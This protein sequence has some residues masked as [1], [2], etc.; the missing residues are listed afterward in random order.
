MGVVSRVLRIHPGEGRISALAVALMCVSLAAIAVGDSGV[1]ALFFD[2]VGTDALPLVYLLQGAATFGVMLGLTGVLG[3]LGPRRAYLGAP[4]A[5]ALLVAIE[6]AIVVTDVGWIYPVLWVTVAVATL[7]QG[8]FLWGIA[9]V[10]VDL[11]QAKRLFPIFGAGGILGSVLG[12]LLTRPLAPAIGAENLLLVWAGGLAGAFVLARIL[13]GG[14]PAARARRPSRRRTSAFRDVT[15]ALAYVRR[16]SLLVWM[17]L[18]GMLFS[19]LFYSLYLPFATAA[20]ERFPD[21]DQLAGFFGLFWAGVTATAF[22]VSMLGTNRLIAWVGVAATVV[23]LPVLYSAAFGILLFG[24]GFATLVALR[25]TIGTWLQGVASPGWETLTNVVPEGRRDQV[26]AFLNG[27]PTQMGTI[28][29]G[30]IALVGQ[31]VLSAGQFA[32]IGLAAAVVTIVA[33]I[34]VRRSY[35]S[36]LVDALRAG[37]PQVFER[38]A[39]RRTPVPMALDADSARALAGS[40][41]SSDLHERRLAFQLQVDLPPEA[42]SPEIVKGVR[43]PDPIVRLAAIRALD[44]QAP[45]ERE[46]LRSL[47][48]DADPTVVA[49]AAARALA[50][51]DGEVAA[52][53]LQGLLTHEDDRIRHAAVEQLDLAPADAAASFGSRLLADPAPEV[54]A[55]AL[56]RVA[57]AA[58]D[59]ALD[60]AL[61]ALRDEDALVRRAAGRALGAADGRVLGF[62]LEALVDDRTA[63][64]A[65]EAI[66]RIEPDGDRDRVRAFVRAAAE[67]AVP[68]RDLA[69]AIPIDDEVTALL[70]DAALDRGRRLARSGLWAA[71]MLGTRRAEMET[72]IE[73]LDG[74]PG[75]VANALETLESAGDAS[76]VRPLL[77]LWEPATGGGGDWL[78]VALGHEDELVRRCAE[79]VRS[80]REGGTM[81]RSVTALSVMERVLFLRRVPLFA[82]LAPVDLERVARLA[83]DQGYADA[84]VIAAEDEI[85]EELHIVVEGTIRVVRDRNGAGQE[86]ARRTSGD[87]V[88]EMSIVTQEPRMATLVADGDVRTVTLGHREFESMLRERPSIALAVMRVL[89]HRVAEGSRS[90]EP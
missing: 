80:R 73:S 49:A 62:A 41:R 85:G 38:V 28:V 37:R 23:V 79:L 83:E 8:V 76:L 53:R 33:T 57:D 12:G 9:G 56:E 60:P 48:D 58:P 2:R 32:A 27:G 69:A 82:D 70:R 90:A 10:V 50:T 52:L 44:I 7:V 39:G 71:T 31:A 66:R 5:L 77:S 15:S 54:R 86:L 78:S 19:I 84:E 34:G 26:R 42:R 11:R 18:A 13:L 3:R 75:Q 47:L 35:T 21:P 51:N 87:V 61:E 59:R 20:T 64:A 43:D 25:F 74:T 68:D 40:L 81:E 55:T 72:A 4:L 88:G 46:A 67:R 29:A 6:R 16:S 45:T 30:L 17:T 89:A 24:S 14:A 1:S 63:D 65:V 36:A 22:V